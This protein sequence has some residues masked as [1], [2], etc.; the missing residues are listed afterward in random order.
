MFKQGLKKEITKIIQ[1][2]CDF[3]SFIGATPFPSEQTS[4]NPLPSGKL[5]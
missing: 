5:T 4:N 2:A 3:G 1:S